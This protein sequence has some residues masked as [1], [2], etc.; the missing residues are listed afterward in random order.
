MRT[1]PYKHGETYSGRLSKEDYGF[2]DAR[3]EA[4]DY[5]R[6][7]KF[8][9]ENKSVKVCGA[10]SE[11]LANAYSKHKEF[12]WETLLK[13]SDFNKGKKTTKFKEGPGDPI[14]VRGVYTF[15]LLGDYHEPWEN[16]LPYA[17]KQL[18]ESFDPWSWVVRE[19]GA[20]GLMNLLSNHFNDHEFKGGDPL[21]DEMAKWR[22]DKSVNIR[23]GAVMGMFFCKLIDKH[24]PEVLDFIEP[25]LHDRERYVRVNLGPFLISIIGLRNKGKYSELVFKKL[26]EWSKIKDENVRWN[27]AMSLSASF[28]RAYPEESLNILEPLARDERKFVWRAVAS[29]LKEI[30]RRNPGEVVPVLGKWKKDPGLKECAERALHYIRNI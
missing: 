22:A 20:N 8:L 29:A 25:L 10:V 27:V 7:L 18:D 2:I 21:Y 1:K 6:L 5:D 3:I 19:L 26:R 9:I 30:G 11:A 23:R 12:V 14:L 17:R 16:V 15:G 28:G 4:E 13:F 24:V